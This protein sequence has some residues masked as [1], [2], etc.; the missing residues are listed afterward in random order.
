MPWHPIGK[1]ITGKALRE[2]AESGGTL[3]LESP[4][5]LFDERFYYNPVIPPHGLTD[6]FGY[7]EKQNL[8]VRGEEATA[9]VSPSDRIYYRPTMEFSDP[10]AVKVTA[11]TLLTPL[12]ETSATP[13]ATCDGMPVAVRKKVGKGQVFYIG[14]NLGAS[15]A[16]G[17]AGAMKFVRAVV[18]SVV[19]PEVTAASV[20]PRLMQGAGETLL[21]VFNDTPQDQNARIE[22]PGD[23]RRATDLH[24]G[25]EQRIEGRVLELWV[26]YQDVTVL[27]LE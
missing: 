17:D 24:S 8:L 27:K 21:T 7:R 11:H 6:V 22:L 5:G 10:I 16:A 12:E 18:S 14:T 15:I 4:Y 19:K 26:A 2:F 9:A 3:I 13:I 25:K 23:F 20:R 1:Q